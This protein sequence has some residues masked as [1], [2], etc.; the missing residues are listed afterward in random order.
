M[1]L[2]YGRIKQWVK[3]TFGDY[4]QDGVDGV[5]DHLEEE[6]GELKE[7]IRKY[8]MEWRDIHDVKMEIADMQILLFNLAQRLG[9][10]YNDYKDCVVMKHNVNRNR[11]WKK[12]PGTNKVKHVDLVTC[13]GCKGDFDIDK[14]L[15]MW[16]TGARICPQCLG[17]MLANFNELVK[18][19]VHADRESD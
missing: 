19:E 7:S 5:L 3:D 17:K 14:T 13:I 6:L 10:C 11:Q 12:V 9:I 1:E 2:I 8:R 15:F 18:P 16:D 4:T